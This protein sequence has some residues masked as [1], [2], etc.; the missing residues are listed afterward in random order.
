LWAE[1]IA[2]SVYTKNRIPHSTLSFKTPYEVLY[3]QQPS[4]DHLKAFGTPCIIH[5]MP[6]EH[7]AGSKLLPRGK[8]AIICGYTDSTKVYRVYLKDTQ[9][10]K[11]SRD[12][13]FPSISAGREL[14]EEPQILE[15]TLPEQP[16]GPKSEA[17]TDPVPTQQLPVDKEDDHPLPQDLEAT[18]E[19]EALIQPRRSQRQQK[20]PGEWWKITPKETSTPT[21]SS[22]HSRKHGE[23]S[24]HL[25]T[26]QEPS[27]YTE[28]INSPDR[29]KWLKAM[30]E[31]LDSLTQNKVL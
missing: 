11:V 1:A 25:A 7:P 5:I 2:W 22:R 18:T 29:E 20:P 30:Q 21:P 6:E 4:L 23:W 10:V 26:I 12:V 24:A 16:E 27:S 15:E 14:P 9:Q 28:A 31:E 17:V 8:E 13:T 3:G 19:P